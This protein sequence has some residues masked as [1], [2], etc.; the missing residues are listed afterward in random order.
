MKVL[1]GLLS[2][3]IGLLLFVLIVGLTFSYVMK[4]VLKKDI[5]NGVV[6]DQVTKQYIKIEDEKVKEGIEEL[7]GKNEVSDL[8]EELIDEYIKY[9]K[10]ENYKVSDELVDKIVDFCVENK[11]SISKFSKEELTEEKIR[12]KETYDNI[13]KTF[14]DG[15]KEVKK[16]LG[17]GE[18]V[19]EVYGVIVSKTSRLIVVGIIL[20]LIIIYSLLN[21]SFYKFLSPLGVS[22]IISGILY[23]GIY[24]LIMVFKD[25]ILKSTELNINFNPKTILIAGIIELALGIIFII[26]RDVIEKQNRL[27][28][29]Y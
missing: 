1:K 16:K 3:I 5:L 10:D 27:I 15:F 20:G 25:L 21:W 4:S 8:A 13:K 29:T 18:V 22:T 24:G 19:V 7:L 9:T 2:G 11:E 14:D 6:K 28:E 26:I 17:D 12:S 23:L